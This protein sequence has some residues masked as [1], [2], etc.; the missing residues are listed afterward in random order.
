MR[1]PQS[2]PTFGAVVFTLNATGSEWGLVIVKVRLMSSVS[3]PKGVQ[4]E[5]I[6]APSRRGRGPTVESQGTARI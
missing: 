1:G 5:N 2:E 3:G 6:G 4:C